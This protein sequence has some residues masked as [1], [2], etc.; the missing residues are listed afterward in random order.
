MNSSKLWLCVEPSI[1]V[2]IK[3]NQAL[4]Y[5]TVTKNKIIVTNT[6]L[7]S[8][9]SKLIN[10]NNIIEVDNDV[11]AIIIEFIEELQKKF[12]GYLIPQSLSDKKPVQLSNILSVQQ[13]I[14]KISAQEKISVTDNILK[15]LKEINI[16]LNNFEN[17]AYLFEANKQFLYCSEGKDKVSEVEFSSIR[18]FFSTININNL[19]VINLLGSDVFEYRDIEKFPELFD[20]KKI[21]FNIFCHIAVLINNLEK[22]K[23]ILTNIKKR[24]ILSVY[25]SHSFNDVEKI[26]FVF[27]VLD[28]L[29]IDYQVFFTIID[30]LSFENSTYIINKFNIEHYNLFPYYN[31]SNDNFFRDNVFNTLNDILNLTPKRIDINQRKTLNSNFFGKITVSSTGEIFIYPNQII[32]SINTYSLL[33][34]LVREYNNNGLWFRIRPNIKPCQDCIYQFLCPPISNYELYFERNNLCYLD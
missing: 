33:D 17:E 3:N 10:H 12:M 27:K 19:E 23:S 30:E 18:N 26:D 9:V 32:G 16:Y 1:N 20:S 11:S 34:C 25:I 21:I 4:L 22:A 31:G 8:F 5:D 13:D 7:L 14:N 29:S 15:N 24:I 28:E 2:C 6:E